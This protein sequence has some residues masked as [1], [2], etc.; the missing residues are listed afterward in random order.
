[1][2]AHVKITTK[3]IPHTYADTYVDSIDDFLLV[4]NPISEK[5][6]VVLNSQSAWV[7]Q[8][9]DNK[10]TVEEVFDLVLKEDNT[11][12]LN[13]L[14]QLLSNLV[15]S[16]VIFF[17]KPEYAIN[18]SDKLH[19]HL[20]VWFHITNQCNLRCTYCYVWKNQEKMSKE[21]AILALSKLITDAQKNGFETITIKFSGGEC[22]LEFP[23]IVYLVNLGKKLAKK[24]GLRIRFSVL[25]NG[26]LLTEEIATK[27]K[28]L[29][30]KVMVSLDGL[31]CFHDSQRVFPSGL[32]SFAFVMR[33]IR[34]LQKV[35]VPFNVSVTIT[36]NNV[37]NIPD[38]TKYMVENKIPFAFNFYRENPF[39]TDVLEKNDEKLIENL[40]LAYQYIYDN[41][42]KQSV[43]N[44][45]LDRVDFRKPHT[46]TCGVGHSYLVIKHDGS[47]VSC[48]MLLEHPIGSIYDQDI[49]QTMKNGCFIVPRNLTV[50]DKKPCAEC[51]WKYIC[52]G[53]CPLLSHEQ[54]GKFD[55]NSPY[56]SVY[57]ALIPLALRIEAKRLINYS[58]V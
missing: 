6:I 55:T 11:A 50:L 4:Y 28:K 38:L 3:S 39:V 1:M 25:T 43:I 42:P 56:C 19:K 40:K 7:F 57:Q 53:G 51:Q 13:D 41:P 45:L 23:L 30:V 31:G 5:K 29:S 8:L 26:V 52:C 21:V 17:D 9:I 22:L 18:L 12:S 44:G 14:I 58:S 16:G 46:Q 20:G 34:F 10:K 36:S 48:Q 49:I 15:A 37:A 27:L 24:A 32:G 33:G 2:I 54:K 35:G 47:I